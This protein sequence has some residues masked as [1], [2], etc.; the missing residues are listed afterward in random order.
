MS[1]VSSLLLVNVSRPI[2]VRSVWLPLCAVVA[3]L[4]VCAVGLSAEEPAVDFARDVQPI[5]AQH[6]YA[7]HGPDAATRQADLRLDQREGAFGETASGTV[8]VSPGEVSHSELYRRLVSSDPDVRMPPPDAEHQPSLS[9]IATLRRWIEAGAPWEELWS[10]QP[11]RKPALPPVEDTAW[12]RNGVDYFV[13]ARLEAEG[14]RPSPPATKYDWLRRVT[15]D[16]TGLPPTPQEITAFVKDSASDA[17]AKVVERLLASPAYGE[18][19]AREWL[20][21]ARYADTHGYNIDSHRD[22]WR[23]REWVIEAYNANMPFDQFHR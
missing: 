16:L 3:G 22:M 6:C 11:V 5:L 12:P 13:L 23:Y 21:L 2:F 9:Q 20:D 17:D 19:A 7:C 15:F 1:L 18:N 4:M 8:P 14:M 10:L